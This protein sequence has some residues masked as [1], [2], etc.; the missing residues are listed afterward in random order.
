MAKYRGCGKPKTEVSQK[1]WFERCKKTPSKQG[2][3]WV[4]RQSK[5]RT[6]SSVEQSRVSASK[7]GTGP[8]ADAPTYARKPFTQAE[9]ATALGTV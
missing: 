2:T 1:L 3:K 8:A 9:M 7:S 5:N 6:E 4:I